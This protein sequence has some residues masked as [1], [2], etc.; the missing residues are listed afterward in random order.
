[1]RM[2]GITELAITKLDVLANLGPLKIA[3]AYELD[4]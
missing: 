3:V 2:N 1:V 4:G